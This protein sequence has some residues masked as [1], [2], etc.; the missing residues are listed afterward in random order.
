[1]SISNIIAILT[2]PIIKG[3]VTTH[4]NV[5]IFHDGHKKQRSGMDRDVALPFVCNDTQGKYSVKI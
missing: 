5:I 4:Q 3:A 1:M 2:S